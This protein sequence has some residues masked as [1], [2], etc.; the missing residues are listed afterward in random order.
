M[1][2][3]SVKK[4]N[5]RRNRNRSRKQRGGAEC[6]ENGDTENKR[7]MAYK[8]ALKEALP[9][10]P[11]SKSLRGLAERISDTSCEAPYQGSVDE[12]YDHPLA[13]LAWTSSSTNIDKV[14]D[15][16]VNGNGTRDFDITEDQ[17]NAYRQK[18]LDSIDVEGQG[19]AAGKRRGSGKKRRGSDKK[20]KGNRRGRRKGSRKVKK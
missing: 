4:S 11:P 6:G 1:A 10:S 18:L 3:K 20:G 16:D 9:P 19:G 2:R 17:Y 14:I 7:W 15:N 5:L 12:Y 13:P 8:A